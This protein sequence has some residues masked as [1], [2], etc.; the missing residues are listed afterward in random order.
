[1]PRLFLLS[2]GLFFGTAN[3]VS[4]AAALSHQPHQTVLEGLLPQYCLFTGQFR[5]KRVIPSLPV[6]LVSQGRFFY[7][8]HAGLIWHTDSPIVETLVYTSTGQQFEIRPDEQPKQLKSR[9]HGYLSIFLLRLMA[10]DTEYLYENFTVDLLA[11]TA[12]GDHLMGSLVL[13]P[14]RK[15][16]KRALKKI[17]LKP[18]DLDRIVHIINVNKESTEITISD[19][20]QHHIDDRESASVSCAPMSNSSLLS[21]QTL[22]QPHGYLSEN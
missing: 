4:Y 8:C 3:A 18:D 11:P 5:Q 7:S 6:P 10:A 20:Q 21:C 9:L 19:V 16:V 12:L 1:M 2:I 13:V 17:T 15:M 14:R 22:L